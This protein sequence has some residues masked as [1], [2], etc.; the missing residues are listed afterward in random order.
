MPID[1]SEDAKIHCFKKDG[2]L[3]DGTEEFQRRAAAFAHSLNNSLEVDEEEPFAYILEPDIVEEE[4][5]E[6]VV[7][8]SDS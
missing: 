5:N 8:D 7:Y 2:P 1:G 3:K 6:I 4:R